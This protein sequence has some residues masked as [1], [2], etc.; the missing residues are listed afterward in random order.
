MSSL[1]I[2]VALP[3]FKNDMTIAQAQMVMSGT[4]PPR[5]GLDDS[6]VTEMQ[7]C[8]LEYLISNKRDL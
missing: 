3:R 1:P 4:M 6:I 7:I 8:Y 2:T 5:K